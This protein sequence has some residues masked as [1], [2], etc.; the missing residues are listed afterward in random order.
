MMKV[1][2]PAYLHL[3]IGGTARFFSSFAAEEWWGSLEGLIIDHRVLRNQVKL[4]A[5]SED[6]MKRPAYIRENDAG[7]PVCENR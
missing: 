7:V 3:Y 6:W 5:E 1:R 4:P 2:F